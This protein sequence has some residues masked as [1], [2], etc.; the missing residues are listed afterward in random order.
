MS[1]RLRN[2]EG[3]ASSGTKNS[4]GSLDSGKPRLSGT[5]GGGRN[6]DRESATR[7]GGAEGF[8][9]RAQGKAGTSRAGGAKCMILQSTQPQ[10]INRP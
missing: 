7:G 5:E 6:N 8:P 3:S 9:D 2:A 1:E 4:I 10:T